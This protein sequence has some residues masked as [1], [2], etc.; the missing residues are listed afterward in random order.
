MG[1]RTPRYSTSSETWQ[2]WGRQPRT[3]CTC[4]TPE[5]APRTAVPGHLVSSALRFHGV[6][7]APVPDPLEIMHIANEM[8][9]LQSSVYH[10]CTFRYIIVCGGSAAVAGA[11]CS[12]V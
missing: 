7:H 9:Q 12:L 10:L 4:P 8:I 6:S 5:D 2:R 3:T 1:A 11:W